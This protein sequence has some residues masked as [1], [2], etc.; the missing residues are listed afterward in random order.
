[1]NQLADFFENKPEGEGEEQK[2]EK[3]AVGEAE[4]TQ[5]ELSE[6]VGLAT[7]VREQEK[8]FNTTFDKVW[9]E[10][11]KSQTRVKALERELE[12]ARKPKAPEPPIDEARAM[13]EAVAA[14]KKL[15]IVT[16]GDFEEYLGKSFRKF[17]VQET[18]AR[19]LL[20]EAESLA[21]TIDGKDGRPKFDVQ[22]IL[23]HM[24]E[25]GIKNPE[26]AYKDK[27]ETELDAWKEAELA[28]AKKPGMVT[29]TETGAGAK[30]PK[31]VKVTRD[32]LQ[33]LV[34]ESLY[35]PEE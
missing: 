26:R 28:K 35:G 30:A 6:M 13:E 3:I 18:A 14:A 5:E 11:G 19:D 25:T 16:K 12:E 20:R 21:K 10:Y 15:G 7:S 9:P 34:K 31:D 22:D 1:V 17:Y 23:Q 32:N 8:K 4:Y 2:V 24:E 29:Q 33:Q 27:F